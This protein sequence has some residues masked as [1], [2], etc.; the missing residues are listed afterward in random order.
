MAGE[1]VS[2]Q[3][4]LNDWAVLVSGIHMTLGSLLAAAG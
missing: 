3:N 1:G 4:L 2:A